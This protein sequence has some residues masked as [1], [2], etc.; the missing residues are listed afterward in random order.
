MRFP[1]T[2]KG[3]SKIETICRNTEDSKTKTESRP[4]ASAPTLGGVRAGRLGGADKRSLVKTRRAQ[5]GCLGTGSRRRTRQAAK[6]RGELQISLDPRVSEWGN[7][8]M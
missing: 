2:I 7:P 3:A 5:D 4:A 6:S 1:D 8:V